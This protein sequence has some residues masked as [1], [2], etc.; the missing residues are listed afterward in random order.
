[1]E[2]QKFHGKLDETLPQYLIDKYKLYDINTAI[3]QIHFP[4]NFQNFNLARRR[5]VFEE[6]FSMQLALLKLK[7]KYDVDLIKMLKCLIL[8]IN[9]HIN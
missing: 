1:M 5:L 6:L 8:L 9:F 3:Q 2:L 7:N 4:D